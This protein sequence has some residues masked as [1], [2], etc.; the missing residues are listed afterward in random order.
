MLYLMANDLRWLPSSFMELSPSDAA[1]VPT[2]E[3]ILPC[4]KDP[5]SSDVKCPV[6][7]KKKIEHLLQCL[8]Y[9][10]G[11]NICLLNK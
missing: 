1:F 8:V 6:E 11:H 3:T 10:K 9:D 5:A 2:K 7:K 4:S